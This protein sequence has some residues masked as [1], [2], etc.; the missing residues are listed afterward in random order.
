[1][2]ISQPLHSLSTRTACPKGSCAEHSQSGGL[3]H[4]LKV[5]NRTCRAPR[6]A[7]CREFAKLREE[8]AN[9]RRNEKNIKEVSF[10]NKHTHGA[11]PGRAAAHHDGSA[12]AF[13]AAAAK[14]KWL[15]PAGAKKGL[16][17]AQKV[18]SYAVKM[19]PS[20]A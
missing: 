12:A 10:A 8:R 2:L 17:T 5:L 4:R 14:G 7:F 15:N 6:H 16:K 18:G 19:Y 13:A 11:Q 3:P 20:D 9:E 1:M